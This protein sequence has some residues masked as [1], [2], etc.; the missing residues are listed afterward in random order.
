MPVRWLTASSRVMWFVAHS[1]CNMK[2]SRSTDEIGVC[3]PAVKEGCCLESM[4]WA[5]VAA[6]NALVVEAPYHSVSGVALVSGSVA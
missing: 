5:R 4:R 3:Q 6:V 1:S 2:S